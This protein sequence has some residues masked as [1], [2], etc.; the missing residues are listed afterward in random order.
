MSAVQTESDRTVGR[1]LRNALWAALGLALLAAVILLLVA[2][3]TALW[4]AAV[5]A[6]VAVPVFWS[7]N[8]VVAKYTPVD[9]AG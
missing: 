6:V 8:A 4:I 1:P 3:W 2:D 7:A 5:V 9:G